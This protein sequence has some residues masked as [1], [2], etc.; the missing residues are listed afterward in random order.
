MPRQTSKG[1]V[2]YRCACSQ[3]RDTRAGLS[4]CGSK[5]ILSDFNFCGSRQNREMRK[6]LRLENMPLYSNCMKPCYHI[7]GNFLGTQFS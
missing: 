3:L 7:A 6:F 1:Q 5:V 4:M 2:V